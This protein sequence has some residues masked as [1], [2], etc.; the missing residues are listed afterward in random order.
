M[1]Y[2][3]FGKSG[4][5]VSEL[6]LGTMTF[7]NDWGWGADKKESHAILDMYRQAGGNFLDT[8]NLYTDGSSEKI[9]GDYLSKERDSWVVATKYSLN[10][11]NT[12]VNLCGNHR[13]N[14]M[15]SVE[16]SLKR[17]KTDYIDLLWLHIW[18]YTTPIEEVMRGL[19]DLVSSGKV[20]YIGISDAPAWVVSSANTLAMLR[21][22][23]QFIGLQI[24]YSLIERSPERDLL[25]MAKAFGLSVT[26]WGPLSGGILTGKYLRK[27]PRN[28][29]LSMENKIV[30]EK[31]TAITQVLVDIAEKNK[32]SPAQIAL[33]W[34]VRQKMIPIIGAKT[35]SQLKENLGCLSVTLSDVDIEKLNEVSAIPLDF[36]G[37]FFKTSTVQDFCF[38]GTLKKI[39][40]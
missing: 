18:D 40:K 15:R 38:G 37:D 10:S 26:P 16:G 23:T 31:E 3:L 35:T 36:P 13:K 28:A 1:K 24:E 7:G 6:C 14:M 20:L 30:S 8:A 5:R 25:P 33:Y 11:K 34:L 32:L 17:L 39:G 12:D 29:R 21:G 4:L 9:I 2:V 27:S 19:D 22:L